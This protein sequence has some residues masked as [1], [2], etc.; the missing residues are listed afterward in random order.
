MVNELCIEKSGINFVINPVIELLSVLQVMSGDIEGNLKPYYYT[1]NNQYIEKI[2]EYFEKYKDHEAIKKYKDYRIFNSQIINYSFNN[3][4]LVLLSDDEKLK[5]YYV[6]LSNFVKDSN[7][8]MFFNKMKDYYQ[9]VLNYNTKNLEEL[10][11]SEN[12][13]KYYNSEINIKMI[14]KIIQSDWGEYLGKSNNEYTDLGGTSRIGEYPEIVDE[15]GITSLIIH[16]CTHPF[17]NKYLT[18]NYDLLAKTEEIYLEL[19]DDSIAKKEYPIYNTYLEDLVVRAIT[20]VIQ[21]KFGYR[22]K[23]EFE[24][25]LSVQKSYGFNYIKEIADIFLN[26]DFQEGINRINILS[27]NLV[28]LYDIINMVIL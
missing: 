28:F 13:S 6:Y 3:D 22:T 14:L 24:K 27:S 5:E 17:V 1:D 23:D 21:Y 16:E 15:R 2:K 25:E 11:L 8:I 18:T 19:S 4:E 12:M 9:E 26:N 7:F 20:A 10:N